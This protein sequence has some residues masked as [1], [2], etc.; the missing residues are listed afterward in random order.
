MSADRGWRRLPSREHWLLLVGI[1]AL[2][3]FAF[4]FV[5]LTVTRQNLMARYER[6]AGRVERMREQNALLQPELTRGQQDEH[7]PG[8]A[9]QYFGQTPPGAGVIIAEPPTMAAPQPA[10]TTSATREPVWI[11]VWKRL[12]GALTNRRF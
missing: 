3:F 10:A 2:V 8:R 12:I 5:E 1:A 4:G 6:A 7:L 9:W 11:V